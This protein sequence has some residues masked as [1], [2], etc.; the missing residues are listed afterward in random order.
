MMVIT[1]EE[2]EQSWRR[3]SPPEAVV[4]SPTLRQEFEGR[5][6]IRVFAPY[7]SGRKAIS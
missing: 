3:A 7:A 4:N 2:K 5:E 1:A 6:K